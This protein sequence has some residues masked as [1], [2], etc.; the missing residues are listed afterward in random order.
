MR[1]R[2]VWKK[3]EVQKL[4][5]G[6]AESQQSTGTPDAKFGKPGQGGQYS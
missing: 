3:P 6:A 1:R 5:A 4:V 2:K